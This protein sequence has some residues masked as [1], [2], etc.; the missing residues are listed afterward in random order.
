LHRKVVTLCRFW[1]ARSGGGDGSAG[2]AGGPHEPM[3]E[4]GAAATSTQ[5]NLAV[6]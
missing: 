1:R 3:I 6:T 2:K 4:C 5:L